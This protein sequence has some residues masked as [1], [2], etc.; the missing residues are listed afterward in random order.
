[1]KKK[2]YYNCD[3]QNANRFDDAES[4]DDGDWASIEPEAQK[5]AHVFYPYLQ[6]YR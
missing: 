5:T 2:N 1:M 3:N 6:I 4:E